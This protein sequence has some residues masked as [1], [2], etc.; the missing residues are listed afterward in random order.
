LRGQRCVRRIANHTL[1]IIVLLSVT[2]P[3]ASAKISA[4]SF[5]SNF[6]EFVDVEDDLSDNVTVTDALDL[7]VNVA[8]E[9]TTQPANQ[10]VIVGQTATFSVAASGLPPLSYQWMKN[11]N[12][13]SGASSSSYTTPVT[14]TADNGSQFTVVVRNLLGSTTSNP[15]MLTV[16]A[17]TLVLGAS[18]TTVSFGNVNTGG[19]NMLPV[20]LTNSGNSNVTVSS[21]NVSGAGFSASGVPAGSIVA[22][23]EGATLKVTF[24]PASAGSVTGSVSVLSDASNSPATVALS[25]TGE[26]ATP[27]TVAITSPTDGAAVSGTVAITGTASD[28]V[29]ISAIQ[30]QVDGGAS[31]TASGTTAWSSSLNTSPLSNAAHTITARATN[32]SGLTASSS[33][34]VTVSNSRTATVNVTNYGATGNGSTDDT[35]AINNAI[36]ALTSGA[37]LLFPCGTY[38]VTSQLTINISNI[39]IDGSGCAVIS[40]TSSGTGLIIGPSNGNPNY[41]SALALSATANELATSFTTVSSLDVNPGDYVRLQQGGEDS[42]QGSGET[43]CDPVGC[44]GELLKVASVAGNTITVTTALHDTYNPSVNAATAQKLM[45]PIIGLTVQNISFDGNGANVYGLRMA[46][47]T[48]STITDVTSRN[49]RGAAVITYG[50]FNVAWT[51]IT[52]TGAGSAQCGSAVWFQ[53]QGDLSIDGMSLSGLNP[54]TGSGCLSNGAFG[55]EIIGSANS[56]ITNLSVDATGASGRPFKMG[57]A[58]WN[59]FNSPIVKNVGTNY[60]GMSIEYWSSHN[61]FNGCVVTDN[62]GGGTGTGNAGINSFGNFNQFNTFNNCTVSGNANVQF[63]VNNFDA[64]RLGADSNVTINGGTYTGTNTVEPVILITGANAYVHDVVINGPGSQGLLLQNPATNGCINHHSFNAG[65]GLGAAI[66]SNSTTNIGSG[67]MV[68]GLSSNLTQ[69]TCTAP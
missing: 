30:V 58:R 27:P 19:S 21:V 52:V 39:T 10:T 63:L 54:G 67:N 8:P 26:T 16:N 53:D 23:G 69:G 35:A 11:G 25:G 22:P 37:T 18:P 43:G 60:N 34:N 40:N 24:A 3:R 66:D 4:S 36:A 61:T 13:I 59:T 6:V 38:L 49:V 65:T 7:A 9:I 44:R 51:N 50:N 15:A 68:N 62:G 31:S 33:I 57:A 48:E 41:G 17:P 55:F 1:L 45:G 64:L 2:A 56:S 5:F 28:G 29:G 14:T 46:G 12:S 47:V 42:S 32:T 20:I